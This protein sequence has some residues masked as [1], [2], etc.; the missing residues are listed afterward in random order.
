MSSASQSDPSDWFILAKWIALVAMVLDHAANLAA[1][2]SGTEA[3]VYLVGIGRC[4]FPLFV[5]VIAYR[6]AESPARDLR[7]LA[8]LIP[9]AFI[10]QIAFVL[11]VGP[12]LLMNV[13]FTLACGVA[14]HFACRVVPDD[15]APLRMRIVALGAGVAGVGL[16]FWCD[17]G[18]IGAL[19]PVLVS[20]WVKE[21]DIRIV[22]AVTIGVVANAAY[23]VQ[24]IP[25]ALVGGL[26]AGVALAIVRVVAETVSLRVVAIGILGRSWIFYAFYPGHLFALAAVRAAIV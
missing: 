26:A 6:L 12:P 15:A 16:S 25:M 18:I 5:C 22:H 9:W 14:I 2:I 23:V 20:R 3:N 21:G 17:Y 7:Y 24:G 4:A 13:L 1:Q 8:R 10:G 11:S 19:S